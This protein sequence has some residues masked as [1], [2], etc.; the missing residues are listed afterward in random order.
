G[1][2]G[3]YITRQLL[4]MGKEVR[5]LTGHAN[6]N[7]F[8]TRVPAFPFNFENPPE[9]VKSLRG[10]TALYNTYWIR[11]PRGKL[12][13]HRAVENTRT[14]IEAAKEAGIRRF[15]HI[16]ITNASKDSPLPYFRGKGIIEN[17][18]MNSGLSYA[19]IRP[20]VIF[21]T[22]DIL[23]NNIAWLLRKFPVFAVIGS[24][25]FL[26]RPVFVNDVAKMT[27]DAG[28]G[29][30]N[31]IVDA[32]GPEIF[33]F[34]EM[35]RLI[36]DTVQSRARIVNVSA[37]VAYLLSRLIGYVTKDVLLT[38][39]EIKGLTSNLLATTGPPTGETLLSEWLEA[40]AGRVGL[41]YASELN[42]H[43]RY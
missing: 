33:T 27:V 12:T 8:G 32:V 38:R 25:A 7:Q 40:N 42:R 6:N 29:D 13:F 36:A 24:G 15:V 17:A 31:M 28:H 10:A 2:T 30:H 16:S 4:S 21:G 39:D 1:Y 19:I 37:Q 18:L 11:F 9:L 5:T 43:Y 23:I 14:L 3:K 22:E 34:S 35:V 26:L 20:T 41:K